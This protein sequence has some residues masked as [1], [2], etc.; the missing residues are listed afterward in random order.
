[1]WMMARVAVCMDQYALRLPAF[2]FPCVSSAHY[3]TVLAPC[4][5]YLAEQQL[6]RHMRTLMSRSAR[7]PLPVLSDFRYTGSNFI[8]KDQ[9]ELLL[10]AYHHLE[11]QLP[12]GDSSTAG[13]GAWTA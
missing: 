6:Q 3:T 9:G 7:C 12:R 5:D 10:D 4:E 1:M 2:R 13:P 8:R 11:R